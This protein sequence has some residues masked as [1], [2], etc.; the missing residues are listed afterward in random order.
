MWA[1][2]KNCLGYGIGQGCTPPWVLIKYHVLFFF[3][4]YNKSR[5]WWKAFARF[6][7]SLVLSIPT[8]FPSG[9]YIQALVASETRESV[10]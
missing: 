6:M 9:V 7:Y 8:H 3:I 2:L 4:P 1:G 5:P 10:A